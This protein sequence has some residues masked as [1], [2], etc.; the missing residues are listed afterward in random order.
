MTANETT[1]AEFKVDAKVYFRLI[2][3]PGH[4]DIVTGACHSVRGTQR[5]FPPK[6]IE[7]TF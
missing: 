2:E 5:R 3:I 7:N 6:Y 1:G 4:F